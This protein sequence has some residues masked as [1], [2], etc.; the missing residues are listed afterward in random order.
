MSE[1]T[2]R[3]LIVCA[4]DFAVHPSA[5]L[6]IVHLA[7]CGRISATSAMVLSPHWPR[8]VALLHDVRHQIDVGLHLDWTSDFAFAAGHGM[9][10]GQAMRRALLGGFD[11]ERARA[12]IEHQLD[13]FEA[14]WGGAPDYVAGHQHV[15]QFD[16][17]RQVLVQVLS[18]RYA[19]LLR[20]PYLRVSRG[21]PGVGDIKTVIISAMGADAIEKIAIHAGFERAVALFGVY[22]FKGDGLRYAGL[23]RRWLRQVVP[24]SILMCHP[25]QVAEP[26]DPIG[27]A[28]AQ[29]FNY[30]SSPDFAAALQQARMR[31]ARGCDVLGPP[32]RP[33]SEPPPP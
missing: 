25:A 33:V 1:P 12:V 6:G 4:D 21:V 26:S 7:R 30:L 11:R 22:D 31:P 2:P 3:Q 18:R 9:S 32:A 24:G 20:K 14:Q 28:R 15:H 10:L 13:L 16:G 29:E 5:S 23:M 27:V 8:D 19:A 17:I